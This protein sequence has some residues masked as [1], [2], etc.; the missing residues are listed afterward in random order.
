MGA[1]IVTTESAELSSLGPRCEHPVAR[2]TPA[3][4]EASTPGLPFSSLLPEAGYEN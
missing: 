2:V 4:L 1:S 3:A